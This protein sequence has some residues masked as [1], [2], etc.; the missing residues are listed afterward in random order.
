MCIIFNIIKNRSKH[1]SSFLGG[2]PLECQVLYRQE[3]SWLEHWL[4]SDKKKYKIR[5]IKAKTI[6]AAVFTCW[7]INWIRDNVVCP[8]LCKFKDESW[9]NNCPNGMR[10][11]STNESP[12]RMTRQDLC[13]DAKILNICVNVTPN[14]TP[15]NRQHTKG[16]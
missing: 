5:R 16:F 7:Y 4:T 13:S 14:T 2:H 6:L 3:L 10:N 11:F 9:W 15:K 8:M 12:L 1:K